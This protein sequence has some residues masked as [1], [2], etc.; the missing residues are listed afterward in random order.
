MKGEVKVLEVELNH[1]KNDLKKQGE[2]LNRLTNLFLD[3]GFKIFREKSN[4]SK[5]E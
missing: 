1:S 4:R 5:S 2:E 3:E